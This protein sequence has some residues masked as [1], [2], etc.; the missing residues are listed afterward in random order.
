MNQ[1]ALV[2]VIIA[3]VAIIIFLVVKNQKDKKEVVDKI[4]NDYPHRKAGDEDI[5]VDEKI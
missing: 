1:T 4:E 2:F 3:G 5:G